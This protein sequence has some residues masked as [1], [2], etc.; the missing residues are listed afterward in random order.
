[1]LPNS[2]PFLRIQLASNVGVRQSVPNSAMYE[3]VSSV[4]LDDVPPE[5]VIVL[6]PLPDDRD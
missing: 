4:S 2:S 6:R 5:P 1:M 3:A